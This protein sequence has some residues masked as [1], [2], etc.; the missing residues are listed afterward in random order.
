M[1][2]SSAFTLKSSGGLFTALMTKVE[3]AIAF[4][5][6]TTN[7]YP[8]AKEYLALWDTGATGTVITKKI[9]DDLGLKPIGIAEVH[10][11][12]GMTRRSVYLV[13]IMLPHKVGFKHVRVIEGT[14]NGFDVLVGMDIISQGDFSVTNANGYT[15]FSFRSPSVKHIDYVEQANKVSAP[16]QTQNSL[17][18]CGSGK[19][20][21]RCHGK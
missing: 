5:P 12:D 6:A 14:L 10:H 1:P 16:I 7:P 17:C 11:A 21:K 4:D 13:N 15:V 20:Y 9:A 3:I 2:P 18:H 8:P 19:K